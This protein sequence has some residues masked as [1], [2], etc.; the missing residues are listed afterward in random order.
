MVKNQQEAVVQNKLSKILRIRD[1]FDAK[2]RIKQGLVFGLVLVGL[3]VATSVLEPGSLSDTAITVLEP[4]SPS[5]N[6][7]TAVDSET[8]ENIATF[9]SGDTLGAT[10]VIAGVGLAAVA[11]RSLVLLKREDEQLEDKS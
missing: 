10:I 8:N 2:Q 1:R 9:S 3:G 7:I 4:G 6:A 5:D 11:G